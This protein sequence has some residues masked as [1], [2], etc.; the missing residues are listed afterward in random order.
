MNAIYTDLHSPAP[1][2]SDEC[3]L[4]CNGGG[5]CQT[6]TFLLYPYSVSEGFYSLKEN[7]RRNLQFSLFIRK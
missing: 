2:H 3:G 7:K 5:F 4:R 1:V 6:Q